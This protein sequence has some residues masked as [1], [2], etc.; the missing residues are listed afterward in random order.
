MKAQITF[1]L[2]IMLLF[3]HVQSCKKDTPAG[4]NGDPDNE[5]PEPRSFRTGVSGLIPANYPNPSDSDWQNLFDSLPEYGEYL[6]MHVSWN[7]EPDTDGIPAT[8]NLAYDI[9]EGQQV[10]PYV[11]IGF[12][13]DQLSQEEADSY[14]EEHGQDFLQACV[15]I[16]E[17]HQPSLMLIGVELNRYY[18]KSESGFN[19]FIA[20]YPDIYNAIKEVSA[21]TQ[22]GSNFQMDYMRGAATRTNIPHEPHWEILDRFEPGMDVVSFTA[23]PFFDYDHPDDIPENYFTQITEYTSQPVMITETGWPSKTNQQVPDTSASEDIQLLYLEK[24]LALTEPLPRFALIWSFQHD[25]E[26]G[27][28]RG[29]FD[30]I[31]LKNNDGSSKK[32]FDE[33]KSLVERP[34]EE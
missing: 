26:I 10:Q 7:E 17:K 24:L 5:L 23:Y 28:A 25:P 16:A 19:D 4:E 9:T 30:Y 27:V 21:G 3:L 8:V 31:A 13:P 11:G 2:V 14:F 15:A 32:V 1:I 18:E 22:V 29:L 20:L 6:G 34:V 33:W 12:E